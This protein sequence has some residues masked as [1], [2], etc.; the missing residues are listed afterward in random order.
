MMELDLMG[1][2]GLQ[3]LRRLRDA[4]VMGGL[5][6]LVLTARIRESELLDA[7]SLGASDIVTKPFSPGLLVHRLR[8]VMES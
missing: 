4:G 1:I 7:L 5:R 2:D 8:R 3:L 6:V